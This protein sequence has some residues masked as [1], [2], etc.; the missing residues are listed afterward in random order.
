MFIFYLLL[1]HIRMPLLQPL[2]RKESLCRST[3]SVC[4]YP[5]IS[6][7]IILFWEGDQKSNPLAIKST[8]IAKLMSDLS[9]SIIISHDIVVKTADNC[10]EREGR[11]SIHGSRS[12]TIAGIP[13]QPPLRKVRSMQTCKNK[14]SIIINSRGSYCINFKL[15]CIGV[16]TIGAL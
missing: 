3:H 4:S 9:P 13:H 6:H 14:P 11:P 16:G 5:N 15:F 2:L 1:P 7:S 12:T 10:S 8:Y